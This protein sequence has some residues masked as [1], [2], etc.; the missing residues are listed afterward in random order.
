MNKVLGIALALI[1][2]FTVSA[3]GRPERVPLIPP[4]E[5]DNLSSEQVAS[6]SQQEAAS[7]SSQ[8]DE[9]QASTEVKLYLNG[10]RLELKTQPALVNGIVMVPMAEIC[11]YFSRT[12]KCTQNGDVLELNDVDNNKTFVITAKQTNAK[13]GNDE[14]AMPAAPI[15]ADDGV[16]LVELSCFRTFLNADNKFKE[17]FT[18][19]YI[20]ESGLC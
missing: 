13:S 5:A 16:L 9:S 15:L 6:A 2:L 3:C 18:A 12:I 10:N 20:T 7:S 17:E 14:I 4:Q 1:V 8:T 19:A 11:E